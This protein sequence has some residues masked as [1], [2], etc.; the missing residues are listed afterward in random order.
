LNFRN[1]HNMRIGRGM[2]SHVAGGDDER[3]AELIREV[4]CPDVSCRKEMG[5]AALANPP[6]VH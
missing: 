1:L 6:F 4:L 5:L 3:A 2:Y